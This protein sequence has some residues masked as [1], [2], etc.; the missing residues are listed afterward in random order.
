MSLT[1][2]NQSARKQRTLK[3]ARKRQAGGLHLGQDFLA[4][5][6]GGQNAELIYFCV[7]ALGLLAIGAVKLIEYYK[8]RKNTRG[9]KAEEQKQIE[10]QGIYSRIAN[11][12]AVKKTKRTKTLEEIKAWLLKAVRNQERR[13][14]NLNKKSKIGY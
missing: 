2:K 3:S 12:W 7:H 13:L 9:Q 8:E 10:Q 14:R 1:L 5:K 11:L 4:L 6:Y